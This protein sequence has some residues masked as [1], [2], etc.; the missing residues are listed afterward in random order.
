M[1]LAR[2]HD[3][4]VWVIARPGRFI[5]EGSALALVHPPG[6]QAT[7]AAARLPDAFS[8]GADRSPQ[9][10][11]AFGIQQLVEVALRAL[12]PGVNEPF[13]AITCIDRLGQG[14]RRLL[15]R[16]EPPAVRLDEDGR[17]RVVA[18]AYACADLLRLAF[19]EIAGASTSPMVHERLLEV[20]GDLAACAQREADRR[21]LRG[22][23]DLVVA[24]RSSPVRRVERDRMD[25]LYARVRRL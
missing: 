18:G 5:V 11:A 1:A 25:A 12:S 17:V 20:L 14:L 6:E 3:V 23:A 24:L 16:E 7:A 13:T 8:V 15:D 10:D 19:E 22:L 2:R 21:E 4:T 9:Q